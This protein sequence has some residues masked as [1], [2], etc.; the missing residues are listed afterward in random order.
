MAGKRQLVAGSEDPNVVLAAARD[1]RERRLAEVHLAGD[2][3]HG[4]PVG[5]VQHDAQG[6]PGERAIGKYVDYSVAKLDRH[7]DPS[8]QIGRMCRRSGMDGRRPIRVVVAD[9]VPE[10]RALVRLHLRRD[11]R[12]QVVGEA[13][14]GGEAVR[15]ADQKRPDV[16]VLDLQ[17][18]VMDGLEAIPLIRGASPKTRILVLSAFPDPYTLLDVLSHGADDYLNKGTALAELGPA[19][20]N[21]MEETEPTV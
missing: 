13:R 8:Y 10:I 21:L 2:A 20:L 7:G 12:F 14:D 18:P 11:A 1:H 9:D 3:L 17:M 4:A 5:K 6:V 15:V 19:L 16:I